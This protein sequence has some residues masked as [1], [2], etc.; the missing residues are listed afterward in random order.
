[1]PE[2]VFTHTMPVP[3]AG[4]ACRVVEVFEAGALAEAAVAPLSVTLACF[5][6]VFFFEAVAPES[7]AD[8]E[9]ETPPSAFTF[10]VFPGGVGVTLVLI[11]GVLRR[12][13]PS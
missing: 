5:G 7:G 13:C 9:A 4:G 1:M 8:C 11:A 3:F 6:V 2:S 10:L 12:L